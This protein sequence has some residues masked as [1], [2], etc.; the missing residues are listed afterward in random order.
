M[1]GLSKIITKAVT[2]I[3]KSNCPVYIDT[4]L[5]SVRIRVNLIMIMNLIIK[6]R[7]LMS[8]I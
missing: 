4:Y 5:R 2:L 7:C 6:K 8:Y 3:N 1:D